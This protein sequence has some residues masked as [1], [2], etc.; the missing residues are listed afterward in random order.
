MFIMFIVFASLAVNRHVQEHLGGGGDGRGSTCRLG[1]NFSTTALRKVDAAAPVGVVRAGDTRPAKVER[2]RC[3]RA[4]DPIRRAPRLRVI[5][6]AH[7]DAAVGNRHPR[8][9][10]IL[11]RGRDQREVVAAVVTPGAEPQLA[12]P[13]GDGGSGGGDGGDGEGSGEAAEARR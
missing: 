13:G 12:A 7:D 6:C 9:G 4:R 8:G 1:D 3:A 10:L 5:F 11:G 2:Q